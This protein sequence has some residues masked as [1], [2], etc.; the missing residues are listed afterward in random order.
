MIF[1]L[2][3]KETSRAPR[4]ARKTVGSALNARQLLRKDACS[5]GYMVLILAEIGPE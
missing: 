4:E 2:E 3:K 1:F 5:Y